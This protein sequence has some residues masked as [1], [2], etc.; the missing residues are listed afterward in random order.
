[1]KLRRVRRE[2]ND[3]FTTIDN[4]ILRDETI[5]LKSKGLLLTVMGL[6]ETWD[7]SVAGIVTVLKEN[8]R[9]I[10][11]AIKELRDAGY[12]EVSREY[13]DGKISSWV[14]TFH[15]TPIL[16]RRN[17]LLQNVDVE[18][19]HVGKST[20][21]NKQ[22]IK[23]TRNQANISL[24]IADPFANTHPYPMKDLIDAFPDIMFSPGQ[25][26]AVEREVKDTPTDRE[27]WKQTIEKYQIEFN[28]ELNRYWPNKITNLLSVFKDFRSQLER[29]QHAQPVTNQKRNNVRDT[30]STLRYLNATAKL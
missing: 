25:C 26:G 3:N 17:L 10:Y 6:P 27:A 23:E 28:P 30:E 21:Y 7:F 13:K 5:T 19:L 16:L 4:T 1:M 20:Q 2:K 18:N 29:K 15:E 24:T 14:Y 8:R 9:A 11:S 22:V 12:V